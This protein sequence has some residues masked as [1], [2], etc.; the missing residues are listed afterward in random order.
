MGAFE[1]VLAGENNTL[2]ATEWARGMGRGGA[3][4]WRNS[5][6]FR[7]HAESLP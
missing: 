6:N 3:F 1:T 7:I 5:P 4:K 2:S